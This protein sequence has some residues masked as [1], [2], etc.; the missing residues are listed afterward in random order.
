MAEVVKVI[1]LMGPTASGKTRLSLELAKNLPLEIISVD[2][3]MIYR[4]MDIGTAKPTI[5]ELQQ[6]P[7]H[8]IDILDPCEHYSAGKFVEEAQL[9]IA[10][11]H[12]RGKIP[13][14]VG[15]TMLY[16][17][18]LKEGLA[19]LPERNMEI[20]KQIEAEALHSGW[21]SLH[22]KLMLI[23]PLAATKIKPFD[24][25]RIERALEVFYLTN[26][27]ISKLQIE[28]HKAN[29]DILAISMV[30]SLRASL[31]AA[32]E[33]RCELMLQQGFIQEVKQLKARGD[34]SLAQASMRAVGYRQVWEFLEAEFCEAELLPRMAAATRQYAKRQ[35][36][37]LRT[38]P[39]VSVFA[40]ESIDLNLEVL[41]AI[42]QFL[43]IS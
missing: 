23:D 14:L 35:L 8:L 6:V 18:A 19:V 11:I 25:Q 5:H 34:L 31:H 2:S 16:F 36:T 20:R 17:K 30:P 32:I 39:D 28:K 21:P 7:H 10:E 29:L 43:S 13:L 1:F 41:Q 42:K 4:G 27:P 22:Q 26:I 9:L 12:R 24:K 33:S 15:G 40:S 38:F 37:W 3:A